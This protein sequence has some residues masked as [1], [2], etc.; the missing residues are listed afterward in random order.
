MLYM[1]V[2][3]SAFDLTENLFWA[4][5]LDTCDINSC[6]AFREFNSEEL[7]DELFNFIKDDAELISIISAV[8]TIDTST[9]FSRFH[10]RKVMRTAAVASLVNYITEVHPEYLDGKVRQFIGE[11]NTVNLWELI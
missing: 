1:H 3:S 4:I 6:E 8:C 9:G 11:D 2:K 5:V 7:V 10:Y